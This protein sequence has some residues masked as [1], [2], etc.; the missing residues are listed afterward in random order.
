MRYMTENEIPELSFMS[1]NSVFYMINS[2]LHGLLQDTVGARHKE[3]KAR[4]ERKRVDAA[5]GSGK[6]GTVE[7]GRKFHRARER[8]AL[9]GHN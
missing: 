5:E 9:K 2:E 4:E 7:Q 3:G 1:C 6:G 8:L